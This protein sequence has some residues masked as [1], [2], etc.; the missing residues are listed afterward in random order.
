MSAERSFLRSWRHCV[1]WFDDKTYEIHRAVR[2]FRTTRVVSLFRFLK[3]ENAR[4]ETIGS[5]FA[6]IVLSDSC[7]LRTAIGEKSEGA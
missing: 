1:L 7:L 2:H 3:D 6:G 5:L 4:C